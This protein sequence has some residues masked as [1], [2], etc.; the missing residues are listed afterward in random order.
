M[1]L[2]P[3]S[4]PATGPMDP[5]SFAQINTNLLMAVGHV[6]T[7]ETT[8]SGYDDHPVRVTFGLWGG[9]VVEMLGT[10]EDI[11]TFL[12]ANFDASYARDEERGTSNDTPFNPLPPGGGI[13]KP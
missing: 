11:Q 2:T 10:P 1:A 8:H 6:Q 4:G 5:P 9:R 13:Q 3:G 12:K 7:I